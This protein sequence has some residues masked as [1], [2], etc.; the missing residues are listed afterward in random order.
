MAVGLARG[1]GVGLGWGAFCSAV[2]G[3][4]CSVSFW[5]E[6]V[7]GYNANSG[8]FGLTMRRGDHMSTKFVM[9]VWRTARYLRK[10]NQTEERIACRKIPVTII[11]MLNTTY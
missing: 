3:R 11:A 7:A 2:P 8:G 9:L 1:K 5:V 4:V 10:S 6:T